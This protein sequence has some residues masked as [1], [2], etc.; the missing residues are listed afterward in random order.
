M[1][2]TQATA[3]IPN[4]VFFEKLHASFF[5]HTAYERWG[6]CYLFLSKCRI[7][8]SWK[9]RNAQGTGL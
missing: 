7:T 8:P 3:I 4:Q 2:H 5:F 1:A 6:S 9:M